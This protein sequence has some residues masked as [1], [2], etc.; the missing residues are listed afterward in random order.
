MRN[1]II[2]G[3]LGCALLSGG[4]VAAFAATPA[5]TTLDFKVKPSTTNAG[6]LKKPKITNLTVTIKGD[7]TDGMGQPATSVALNTILPR[8]WRINS[9]R[10]PKKKR[11]SIQKV[12]QQKSDKSCPNG[13]KVG[14]GT[15]IAKVNDGA[16]TQKLFVTAYVIENGDIGFFLK[17]DGGATVNQMIV[18]NTVKGFKLNVKIPREIQ[19]PF[20]GLPTGISLLKVNFKG[21]VRVK[22]KPI[23]I[24]STIG[25]P[26]SKKWRFTEVNVYRGGASNKDTD[27]VRCTK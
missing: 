2:A 13:S 8:Q 18:G 14:S 7:T 22:G 21:S 3:A 10:W 1:R 20:P 25:C 17:N 12:N 16:S 11:C 6:T 4:A 15:S 9:E 24:L 23:G 19:E 26:K 5:N 27:T